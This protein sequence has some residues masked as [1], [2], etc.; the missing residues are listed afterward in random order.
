MKIIQMLMEVQ[1][2]KSIPQKLGAMMRKMSFD[3]FLREKI[4]SKQVKKELIVYFI[5]IR[6]FNE[7]MF[8]FI[9]F[10]VSFDKWKLWI[11]FNELCK[12]LILSMTYDKGS[13]GLVLK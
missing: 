13:R 9:E 7:Q 2:T 3:V 5:F 10:V 4:L 11:N 1:N 8:Q 12:F 6:I